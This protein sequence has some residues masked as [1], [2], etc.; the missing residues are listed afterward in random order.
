MLLYIIGIPHALKTHEEGYL[1]KRRLFQDLFRRFLLREAKCV[2]G[3]VFALE[4][5]KE[6]SVAF[7]ATALG[8]SLLGNRDVRL[9]K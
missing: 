2:K 1:A 9:I 8:K 3:V 7:L 5:G 6:R 4:C